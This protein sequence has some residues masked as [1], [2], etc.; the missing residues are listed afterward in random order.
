MN[1]IIIL[2]E[3]LA[4]HLAWHGAR[5]NF[6]AL[7]L[8][9]LIRSGTVNLE[10]LAEAF[11]NEAK[12]ASNYKRLQ[13]FFKDYQWDEEE[14]AK[15]IVKMMNIL[16]PWVLSVDRTTWSFGETTFNILVLGIV[17]KGI[18]YPVVWEMLKKREIRKRMKE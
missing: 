13:R 2:R 4:N 7:F 12:Q 17:H 14:I 1:E 18:T 5:L 6:L 15:L 8:I 3:T 16:L 11:R 10:K 9:A